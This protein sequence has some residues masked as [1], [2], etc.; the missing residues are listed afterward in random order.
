M[1]EG[2]F[3]SFDSKLRGTWVSNDQGM[4]SGSL[5]TT[6]DTITIDGYEED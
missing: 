1:T 4:Y 6:S 3:K 5:K 2:N